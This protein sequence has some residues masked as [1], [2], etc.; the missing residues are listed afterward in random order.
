MNE[1]RKLMETLDHIAEIGDDNPPVDGDTFDAGGV[2]VTLWDTEVA[3][4][5]GHGQNIWL[6]RNEWDDFVEAVRNLS[7]IKVGEEIQEEQ[8]TESAGATVFV[9]FADEQYEGF[10]PI[11]KWESTSDGQWAARQADKLSA[12]YSDDI[13][14]VVLGFTAGRPGFEEVHRVTGKEDITAAVAAHNNE[15]DIDESDQ[16]MEKPPQM[17]AGD[18]TITFMDGGIHA[19]SHG[20]GEKMWLAEEGWERFV[21]DIYTHYRRNHS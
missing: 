17:M 19:F 14:V 20:P 4:N 6:R 10:Y 9:A 2:R 11:E 5:N 3:L 18:V 1:M 13:D 15:R 21:E 8:I 12:T 7:F 16:Y